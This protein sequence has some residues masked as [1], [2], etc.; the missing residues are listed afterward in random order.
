MKKKIRIMAA[1]LTLVCLGTFAFA[2]GQQEPA[3][4][5]AGKQAE[6]TFWTFIEIH[7]KF[8]ESMAQK[9]NGE[10]PGMN[11]VLTTSTIPESFRMPAP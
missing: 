1:A 6:V 8:Y 5:V 2:T 3:T 9:F 11:L 7:Q 4:A 10:N